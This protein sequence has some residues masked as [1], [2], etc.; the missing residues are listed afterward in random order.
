MTFPTETEVLILGGGPS[1]LSAAMELGLRGVRCVLVE[2]RETVTTDRP[3][4]KTTSVRTMEHFRRWGLAGDIRAAAPIPVAWSQDA[5]FC[6]SLLGAEITRFTGCF[7]LTPQ[8][9]DLFAE[10]GQQIAQPL[11]ERVL[12]N[13]VAQLDT[14]TTSFGALCGLLVET[15]S[16]VEAS[17]LDSR[18]DMHVLRAQYVLGCDGP[19]GL[20]RDS[21]GALYEGSADS[22]RNLNIVFRA[23]G[24]AQRVPHGSAVHY[25]VVNGKTSGLV[26]R[27]D[28]DDT[29]FVVGVDDSSGTLDPSEVVRALVGQDVPMSI[30]S[31]D[32]WSARMLV[33]DRFASDRIFLVGDAAHLTPPW[34]GHGFN[35]GVGDAVNIGWKLAA[36][37]DGW[38]G[39]GLL[40]TY[41]LER[42]VV[43]E[44]TIA[45]A[46]SHLRRTPAD[47]ATFPVSAPGERGRAARVAAA[48]AIQ[49]CKRSEFHGLGLVLGYHY[50]GSP[51]IAAD[52]GPE[53][54]QEV[55]TYRPT[56]QAGARLPHAWLPDG[57]SLYDRLAQNHTLLCLDPLADLE[58][59]REAAR[60]SGVP[61]TVLR[62]GDWFETDTCGASLVLVRPDQHVAWRGEP[63]D[64]R[65]PDLFEV[66]RGATPKL[67]AFDNRQPVQQIA[68]EVR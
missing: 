49:D 47:L 4:A 18:D 28:L 67:N 38:G 59:I 1:G 58:P 10:S 56:A 52:P 35:T 26:G 29:W 57:T 40:E 48:A 53:P 41:E 2:P 43:A 20:S 34:G 50:H 17:V 46:S 13:A 15:G 64:L 36:V 44:R 39:P 24:L 12:R 42:R 16:Y 23:P 5:V 62:A 63:D 31:T 45:T 3:R 11:V 61:L 60:R 54:V 19:T 21:I 51:I 30:V 32:R 9:T 8:R 37:L 55:T 14:V 25:W 68:A 33:A 66:V 27:L 65:I 7:G 6:T 22:R